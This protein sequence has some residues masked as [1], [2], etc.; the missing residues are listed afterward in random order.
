MIDGMP[1]S[2]LG[3]DCVHIHLLA[4]FYN[5]MSCEH[6]S[7][8]TMLS[9][10]RV[11]NKFE[12]D[13]IR[14]EVLFD[15]EFLFPTYSSQSKKYLHEKHGLR[16]EEESTLEENTSHCLKIDSLQLVCIHSLVIVSGVSM[17]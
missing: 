11:T 15:L 7:F 1:F 8:P 13:A 3:I 16:K 12:L 4:R 9:I 10:L 5:H 17:V 2:L 14:A 6:I